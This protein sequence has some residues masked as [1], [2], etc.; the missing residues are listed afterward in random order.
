MEV[1]LEHLRR[2]KAAVKIPILASLN[3]ATTG[4]WVRYAKDM[5]QAGADAIELNTY[6]LAT[7]RSQTSAELEAQ[8]LELVDS[9]LPRGEG[10]G[11]GEA[12]AV[13]YLRAAPG[14]AA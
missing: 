7:D 11:S 3:G 8:L 14:G 13:V 2:A 6:A 9:C 5:E 10:S 4:G 1:Y 12:F